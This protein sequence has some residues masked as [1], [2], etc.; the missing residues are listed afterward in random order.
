M[1]YFLPSSHSQFVC[2]PTNKSGSLEDGMYMGSGF[3]IHSASL[4][5]LVGALSPFIFKVI[6]DMGVSIAVLLI[7]FD[8][9]LL[10][11]FLAFFSCSLLLRFEDPL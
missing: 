8:L 7:V 6:I 10:V 5:L 11:F 9:F 4:C 3:C 2:V 1:E